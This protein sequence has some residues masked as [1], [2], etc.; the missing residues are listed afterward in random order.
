MTYTIESNIPVPEMPPRSKYPWGKLHPGDSILFP[1]PST[2]AKV[3]NAVYGYARRNG[4]KIVTRQTEEG[5][6]IW[7]I[8]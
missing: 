7:R 3:L 6:R 1:D 2:Y 8:E 5:L 4:W